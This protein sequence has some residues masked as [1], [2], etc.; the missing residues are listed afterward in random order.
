VLGPTASGKSALAM[1]LADRCGGEIVSV[2]SM[3]VYRGMDIGTAKPSAA[4]RREVRHHLID[5]A[6]PSRE[7]SVAEFQQA[8]REAL[9]DIAARGR[10]A[11]ICGG[12]GLHF[13]ALVDPLDFPPG[14]E[15][16]R[17]ELEAEGHRAVARRLL[18]ADPEAASVVDMANPRRVIRGMEIY[19]L[20]GLTPSRRAATREAEAVRSYRPMIEFAAVGVDP[21]EALEA[22]VTER[23]DAM[24]AA[25]WADEA[26]RLEGRLGRTAAAAVGYDEL[27][28]AG[29]DIGG[30]RELIRAATLALAKRQRTFFR[31]DPRIHWLAWDDEP[32]ILVASAEAALQEA[33]AWTS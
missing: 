10:T 25:G 30:A 18:E 26:R 29:S 1:A 13:R 11:I 21:G 17:A 27:I 14:D 8:G 20:T 6:E 19:L 3:Q 16:T 12:S 2:D 9:A 24:L 4:D 15:A 22:R 7:Y 33:G 32:D 5:I 23:L 31:R 28:A